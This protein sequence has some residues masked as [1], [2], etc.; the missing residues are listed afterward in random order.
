MD[1]TINYSFYAEESITACDSMTWDNG[2]TYTASGIY[3]D[4]LL[5]SNGCDSVYMLDLTINP[6]PVFSFAQDTVGACGSDSV[7]L[8]A[9]AGHTN[10]LWNTGDTTQTIY[11]SSTGTYNVTVGN[12]SVNSSGT[13]LSFDGN[14]DQASLG[15][16]DF[17]NSGQQNEYTI[18]CWLKVNDLTFNNGPDIFIFG[19][20]VNQNNGVMLSL[21]NYQGGG[22]AIS[23][24]SPPTGY[25]NASIY[26]GFYPNL[27]VWC[28]LVIQQDANGIN[29][30]IN[31]QLYQRYDGYTN[32]DNTDDFR[33]GGFTNLGNI[34]RE[35]L[36]HLNDL[37]I[38]GYALSQEEIK[39]YMNCSPTGNEVGLVGYWN[40][41][42]G[43]GTTL[44]DL[45]GNGNNGTIN[46]ASWSNDTP[47]QI[48]D[49]CTTTD[50]IYVEILDV[51]IVQ[52]DTTICQGDSVELSVVSGING[53]DNLG[54]SLNNG[55]VAYYPFNGNANDESGNGNDGIINGPILTAGPNWASNSA[56]EFNGNPNEYIIIE[57]EFANGINTKNFSFRSVFKYSQ[58]DTMSIWSKHDTWQEIWIKTTLD[59]QVNFYF[60]FPNDTNNPQSGYHH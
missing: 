31:G 50:S 29:F 44:T 26:T 10:Y 24:T 45:S 58:A 20:E 17:I 40:M 36:G 23:C 28:N 39:H 52:N 6:S 32:S 46:G 2:I 5:T 11:A 21:V 54:G 60:N 30:Y 9:G 43:S 41:D 57:N 56:Y 12:G 1:L 18:A 19:D 8:D 35:L 27:G 16:I 22:I 48:C 13:S 49:N 55:L 53:S 38:W 15:D 42:E 7:L 47:S 25:I 3:Y 33:I 14:D 51:D 34:S 4:S 37:Q 59:N